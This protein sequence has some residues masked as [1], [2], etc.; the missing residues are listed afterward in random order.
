[1]QSA[2]DGLKKD[3]EG[4]ADRAEERQGGAEAAAGHWPEMKEDT[5]PADPP[6]E[7]PFGARSG[8]GETAAPPPSPPGEQPFGGTPGDGGTGG[9]DGEI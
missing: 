6:M 9:T 5:H 7:K 2:L 3:L 4:R 8:A 1:M